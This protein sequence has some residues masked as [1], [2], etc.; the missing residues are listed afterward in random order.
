MGRMNEKEY[1]ERQIVDLQTVLDGL[2]NKFQDVKEAH[3]QAIDAEIRRT[4]AMPKVRQ[5]RENLKVERQRLQTVADRTSAQV[6]AYQGLLA[7]FHPN[8]PHPPVEFPLPEGKTHMHGI[9][10]R[11]LDGETRGMVVEGNPDTIRVLGGTVPIP[12]TPEPEETNI[13]PPSFTYEDDPDNELGDW[14]D[15]GG[16]A[17]PNLDAIRSMMEQ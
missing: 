14:D 16:S 2:Q 6:E 15:E 9:D 11:S 3:E 4:G 13:E 1:L 8:A 10:L 7:Q 17:D 5:V 12:G